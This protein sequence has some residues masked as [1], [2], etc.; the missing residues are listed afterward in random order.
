MPLLIPAGNAS[1]WT[2]PTGNNTYLLPGRMPALVDAGVGQPDHIEAVA[3]ALAGRA[4]ESVLVTHGHVDHASGAPALAARW[5][6]VRIRRF[7]TGPDPLLPDERLA[8]GDVTL[9]VVPTPGHAPDHVCFLIEETRDLLCGDLV[10]LGGTIVIP[11]TRGGDLREYL[12]SLR[13]VRD[14][15]PARLLPG[16]G[17]IVTDPLQLIDEYI[18]HRA[19]REEQ[20]VAALTPSGVSVGEI[21]S[22][23]YPG[24]L[25]ALR[26]A[27]EETT[28]AH[29]IKLSGEGRALERGGHWFQA[30]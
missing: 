2:G 17:P 29:L 15:N 5:P 21:V 16:H 4:L 3:R 23:V 9:R 20:I 12:E 8:A 1:A 13:R 7:G 10:R 11:A 14:L 24:L 28:L 27:A 30:G 18:R 19:H 25:A 26:T 6:G 22:H